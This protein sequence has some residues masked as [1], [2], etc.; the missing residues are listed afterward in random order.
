MRVKWWAGNGPETHT[1][2]GGQGRHGRCGKRFD[3]EVSEPGEARLA[4]DSEKREVKIAAHET[5]LEWCTLG[6]GAKRGPARSC[7]LRRRPRQKMALACIGKCLAT[8]RL[9]LRATPR[10]PPF[11]ESSWSSN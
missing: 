9:T 8:R 3:E 7:W 11:S 10:D 5:S 2:Y 4:A 6:F 1:P